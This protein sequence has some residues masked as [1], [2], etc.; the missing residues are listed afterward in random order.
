[1]VF[2]HN[3][4][5]VIID[6]PW[7]DEQTLILIDYIETQLKCSLE[8]V[9]VTHSHND[10]MGGLN[11]IN[12]KNIPSYTLDKTIELCKA[13]NFPLPTHSFSDSLIITIDDKEVIMYYPG[14]GHSID[15]IVAYIP[16]EKVLFAGCIVKNIYNR[17]TLP[18]TLI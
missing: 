3:N 5:A 15:N 16:S 7:D 17:L 1:M 14:A 4:K 9:I 12:G 18:P 13:N 10:C 11:V 2:T 8:A 6:T